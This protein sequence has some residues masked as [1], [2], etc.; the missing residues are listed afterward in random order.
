MEEIFEHLT[1]KG[2]A[3]YKF[4]DRCITLDALPLTAVG[5]KDA[6]KLLTIAENEG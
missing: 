6:K 5:K 4:P 1:K 2:V 3:R